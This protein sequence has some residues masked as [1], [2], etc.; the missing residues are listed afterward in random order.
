MAFVTEW[1]F[2]FPPHICTSPWQR[3]R[4]SKCLNEHPFL[5]RC[6]KRKETFT[7]IT[8]VKNAFHKSEFCQLKTGQWF[9]SKAKRVQNPAGPCETYTESSRIKTDIFGFIQFLL[10]VS[11]TISPWFNH[12]NAKDMKFS[13]IIR[14][15]QEWN[16]IF[17]CDVTQQP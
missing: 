16:L 15:L 7:T 2:L 3:R 14:T 1:W 17:L 9:P 5:T 12:D 13:F 10:S 11:L 4:R 8:A 6:N